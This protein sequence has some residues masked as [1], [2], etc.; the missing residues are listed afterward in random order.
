MKLLDASDKQTRERAG[1]GVDSDTDAK[2]KHVVELGSKL[3][4]PGRIIRSE[5]EVKALSTRRGLESERLVEWLERRGLF[6]C[7]RFHPQAD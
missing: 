6:P 7:R 4:T 5:E 1:D 3:N 2:E